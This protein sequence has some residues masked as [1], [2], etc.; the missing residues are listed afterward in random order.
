MRT[1]HKDESETIR[2]K[3]VTVDR[4]V[5]PLSS[6]PR[7]VD[8][9]QVEFGQGMVDDACLDGEQVRVKGQ[10][11][12]T[13]CKVEGNADA[14]A[15]T[16]V[17]IK[18]LVKSFCGKTT[19]HNILVHRCLP[20]PCPSSTGSPQSAA[21]PERY[22]SEGFRAYYKIAKMSVQLTITF[23][24]SFRTMLTAVLVHPALLHLSNFLDYMQHISSSSH[25]SSQVESQLK[26]TLPKCDV[27]TKFFVSGHSKKVLLPLGRNDA[28]RQPE[29]LD[30][31]SEG[32][33]LCGHFCFP[34]SW[35]Y[36]RVLSFFN[37]LRESK[38]TL[39]GWGP[40]FVAPDRPD[41]VRAVQSAGRRSTA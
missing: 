11:P 10:V 37:M 29:R 25:K 13:V 14:M 40:S 33:L 9:R 3:T 18:R 32:E 17:D 23:K 21:C 6:Q 15:N 20:D 39:V 38:E 12:R 7:L 8:A 1:G 16:A 27:G 22:P 19:L 34:L 35:T 26:E 5:A 41:Q 36:A 2:N 28:V 4:G 31:V 30:R 24:H